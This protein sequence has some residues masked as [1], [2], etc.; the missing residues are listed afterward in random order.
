MKKIG[1]I[2]SLLFFGLFAIAQN[3]D[4]AM[5]SDTSGESVD[6]SA[7]AALPA[8][9][10]KVFSDNAIPYS[11]GNFGR[12]IS[13]T[14]LRAGFTKSSALVKTIVSGDEVELLK[15]L[16][17][18]NVWAVKSGK[19]YGFVPISSVMKLKKNVE[20]EK[21]KHDVN[22]KL[23]KGITPKLP[24]SVRGLEIA[25]KVMLKVLVNKKGKVEEV[26]FLHG[27]KELKEQ[28][29]KAAKK[30]RFTPAKYRGKDVPA[31][32]KVPVNFAD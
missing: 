22:P 11:T 18:E 23:V 16:P 9:L 21:Y 8:D 14:P 12:I 17:E 1:L 3:T 2:F 15:F 4:T 7:A 24:K 26:K 10:S 32:T 19:N 25:H 20:L 30:L 31:W 29:L 27:P 28:A 13:S 6:N 5:L